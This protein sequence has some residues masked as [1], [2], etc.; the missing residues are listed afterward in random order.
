MTMLLPTMT[1]QKGV[2][3]MI[4]VA[5]WSSGRDAQSISPSHALTAILLS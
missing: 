3:R 2:Y 4:T 1:S 5:A